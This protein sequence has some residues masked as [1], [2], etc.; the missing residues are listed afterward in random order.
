MQANTCAYCRGSE[1][2]L[3]MTATDFD[4]GNRQF[5]LLRC[6]RCGLVQTGIADEKVVDSAY[7]PAYYGST[8]SKFL[9]F[10]EQLVI[11]E[12][13]ARA[14]KIL[15]MY[16]RRAGTGAKPRVLDIGCGRGLLLE[17][18]HRMGADCMGLERESFPPG[19]DHGFR[20]H[21]G[22]LSDSEFDGERFDIVVIWHVLEHMDDL[23]QVMSFLQAHLSDDGLLVV[24]VPNYSSW[25]SRLFAR[26]WFHLD[27]P[28]HLLHFEREWLLSTLEAT[29]LTVLAESTFS[30]SQNFYGFIQSACNSLF[31]GPPNRLYSLLK[32]RRR[33]REWLPLLGWAC[34]GACLMP[35]AIL[36]SLCAEPFRRG[37]TLTLFLGKKREDRHRDQW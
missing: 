9:T 19:E 36:E 4:T 14:Q 29:G 13:R 1:L 24:S 2:P 10:F 21:V 37:A 6:A 26:H 5:E 17:S 15:R 33:T 8:T 16:R 27:L 23:Q 32:F 31:P 11:R 28:R 18:L 12:N 25:Q 22:A 3:E 34:V 30:A 7:T 35:L 20:V